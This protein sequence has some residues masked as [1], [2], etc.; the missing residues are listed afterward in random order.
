MSAGKSSCTLASQVLVSGNADES[1][2]QNGSLAV[3]GGRDIAPVINK[4]LQMPWATTIASK[5]WH[6]PDHVSFDTQHEPP[7]NEAFVSQAVMTNPTN[8]EQTMPSTIWPVHCVQNTPG[9]ELIPEIDADRIET[10]VQKGRDRRVEM[11]SCFADMFGN[12]GD[13]ASADVAALLRAKAVTDVFVVGLTGDCC[14]HHTA[15][16][17]AKEGFRTYVVRDATRSVDEGENGWLHTQKDLVKA[18]VNIVDSTDEAVARVAQWQ[19]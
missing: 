8:A 12:K 16:D 10:L 9:A 5:D 18:G 7:N 1:S 6:P 13:A 19:A 4:L 14:V 17:A 11:Y 15:L 2:V 3:P